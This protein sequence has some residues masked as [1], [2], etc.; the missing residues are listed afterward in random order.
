MCV[1]ATS[2][3][4]SWK[5]KKNNYSLYSMM[6]S[7]VPRMMRSLS[8]HIATIRPSRDNLSSVHF[9]CEKCRVPPVFRTRARVVG[10]RL[11]LVTPSNSSLYLNISFTFTLIVKKFQDTVPPSLVQYPMQHLLLRILSCTEQP[12]AMNI[13]LQ[14]PTCGAWFPHFIA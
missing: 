14:E 11:L 13:L 12:S 6:K 7:S 4:Y 3:S 10:V 5:G 8:S 1:Y 9:V 2:L